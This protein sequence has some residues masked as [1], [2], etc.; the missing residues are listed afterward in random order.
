MRLL[1]IARHRCLSLVRRRRRETELDHEIALHLE[2]L[3]REA[4]AE[5]LNEEEAVKEARRRFGS[6]DKAKE[7]CR[8][9][10]R[11]NLIEDLI[12]DARFALRMLWKSPGFTLTALASLT[13]GIGANAAIFQF[14]EAVRL[15]PLPVTRPEELINIGIVGERRGN[16]RGR[17]G[18]YSYALW[19][20]LRR[21]QTSFKAVVAYG[22]SGFNLSPSGEIR[23][24][25]G[26]RVSGNFFRELGVGAIVG[27][28]FEDADDRPGCGWDAAVI[29]HAF[30]QREF[31][32]SRDVLSRT[33]VVDGH[34]VPIIG[35]TPPGFL[36][37]EVGRS[38]DLALPICTRPAAEIENRTVFFL[39]VLGRLRPDVTPEAA[40]QEMRAISPAL[41][42]ATL[43]SS[44]QPD[45][46]AAYRRLI[47]DTSPG[48]GGKSEFRDEITAP[49]DYLLGMVAL[50]L[51]LACANLSNMMLAR[52]TSREHEFAVRRSMGATQWRLV[53]QVMVESVVLSSMGAIIGGLL[54]PV[55][56]RTLVAMLSSPADPIVIDFHLN[57][58]VFLFSVFVAG[59]ATLLFGLPPALRAAR[60]AVRGAT[61][62]R[63]T[64]TF[65][66]ALLA[67]Q[68][69]LS[70]VLVTA[71]LLF[72]RSFHN[73][74]TTK[75]GF[76]P[77]GVLVAHVFLAEDRYPTGAR[78][79]VIDDLAGR[80]RAIPG[81]VSV[82]RSAII[83]MGGSSMGQ[84]A[85]LEGSTQVENTRMSVV[86][87]G[88]FDVMRMRLLEGRDVAVTD[89]PESAPVAVVNEELARRLSGGRDSVVGRRIRFTGSAETSPP[90]LIVGVV[91]NSK[92]ASLLE[93][94]SPIVYLSDR[95]RSPRDTRIRMVIRT[96][97]AVDSLI[98]PV[99]RVVTDLDPRLNMRFTVLSRQLEESVLRERLM[100]ALTSAFGALGL[101]LALTGVFGVT[102]YVVSRR[103]REF[104]VR[105]A[106]GARP[107]DIVRM[108]LADLAFVL[109]LGIAT[110][111]VIA[112][113]IGES[114]ASLLFGVTP[115][116]LATF[117]AVI[118]VLT[119]GGLLA[120]L[121]PAVR[122]S[123][124]NP[125]EVL[126]V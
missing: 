50:V 35:V 62:G 114:A 36:G 29:S 115:F 45:S 75:P 93:P 15:R 46:Q 108:V 8:D 124:V 68:M 105:L 13:L 119:G 44:Y 47:L 112:V 22:D 76:D 28:V 80:V 14:F 116:D 2:A 99:R 56:G 39:S 89:R 113:F 123:R 58:R 30:W 54:A 61:E 73:L 110:G 57:A 33:L 70:M 103:H 5:G 79:A 66:R 51:L 37:V 12:R 74:Q 40:R 122:G 121:G 65:R 86:S 3:I 42:E 24:A 59:V 88:Y 72:A 104:G 53:Q 100:A 83:P 109:S 48:A 26:L 107:I 16:F 20:E 11:V 27:R 41:F 17:N 102:A 94:A 4:R 106:M 25:N 81:V 38:F 87:E 64:M 1:R 78:G 69:A 10:R 120:A 18:E 125:V 96:S 97:S 92:Y 32:A 34:T 118:C 6:I 82:A 23:G 71:A 126:R 91:A 52:A 90:T 63:A 43:P 98:A 19:D 31:G 21:R 60:A 84:D 55:I 67:A 111:G 7:E 9:E 77:E 101:V 117:A 95:Q 85:K 49:L